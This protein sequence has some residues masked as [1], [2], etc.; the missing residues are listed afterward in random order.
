M[1]QEQLK[2]RTRDYW[3]MQSESEPDEWLSH[4]IEELLPQELQWAT[5]QQ[6]LSLQEGHVHTLVLLVGYSPE[7]LFQALCV[8]KPEH[9][10]CIASP[11]YIGLDRGQND[12]RNLLRGES[13]V[14]LFIE[15][16]VTRL[17]R[18]NMLPK[19]PSVTIHPLK[20]TTPTAVFQGLLKELKPQQTTPGK[21]IIDVT[22]GKKSMVTGAYLYAA[23]AQNVQLSYVDFDDTLYDPDQGKP[24][25]FGC[26]IG[27]LAN[28]YNDFA[29]RG[30]EEVRRFYQQYNFRAAQRLLG[31]SWQTHAANTLW[32][33]AHN[34][35]LLPWCDAIDRLAH[36][37]EVYRL[38][39]EGDYKGSLDYHK[40]HKADIF[41]NV[42]PLPTAIQQL[43]TQWITWQG[44]GIIPNQVP[45]FFDDTDRLHAYVQDELARIERLIHHNED[46]RSAFLRA[47]GL[48]EV[49]MTVRLT[50]RCP[51]SEQSDLLQKL[52][53][54]TPSISSVFYQLPKP[55][56]DRFEARRQRIQFT[57]EGPS[58]TE[59][60]RGTSSF[61]EW[62]DFTELRN[63]LAHTYVSVPETVA[64]A[65]LTFVTANYTDFCTL[66]DPSIAGAQYCTESMQWSRL[67]QA[68]G[69]DE[70]LHPALCADDK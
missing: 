8:Y 22:G 47:G 17:H 21:V 24:F 36:T 45:N 51:A 12:E 29:L 40:K 69:L 58:M 32:S 67:C 26:Q 61:H 33:I 66:S 35:D 52:D 27:T 1:N 4:Y 30:W 50:R 63:K 49:L 59:W 70:W 28:S 60:W 62:K 37:L 13:Y 54:G 18:N 19:T 68:C 3:D 16:Y 41:A 53:Q 42:Q 6:R 5:Q 64:Q 57:L 15:R 56:G 44:N 25:G 43:G 31:A 46:Y 65:A 48:N 55:A 11:K 23:F 14:Q 9:I 20:D 2:K 38:W 34:L 39:D 10:L 7:P